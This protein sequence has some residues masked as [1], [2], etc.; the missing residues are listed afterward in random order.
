M[1]NEE[2]SLEVQKNYS[3]EI[4]AEIQHAIDENYA[5]IKILSS[6]EEL[7]KIIYMDGVKMNFVHPTRYDVH[8]FCDMYHDK[9]TGAKWKTEPVYAFYCKDW[10]RLNKNI[11]IFENNNYI[12]IS[13]N[14]KDVIV[15][16]LL[17]R[18]DIEL[19][20]DTFALMEYGDIL[21]NNGQYAI[22]KAYVSNIGETFASKSILENNNFIDKLYDN[23]GTK[24]TLGNDGSQI[25]NNENNGFEIVSLED[26]SD[27]ESEELF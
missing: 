22:I 11:N 13:F 14:V 21:Y 1:E 2:K 12:S 18:V 20:E 5:N 17:R 26:I 15:N 9:E 7:P 23:N 25:N 10:K 24:I 6:I 16:T 19:A 8:I 4:I 27:A 3:E